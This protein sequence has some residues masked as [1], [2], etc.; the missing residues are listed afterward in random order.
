[1]EFQKNKIKIVSTLFIF[2]KAFLTYINHNKKIIE[3]HSKG[4]CVC[5]ETDRGDE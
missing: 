3:N 5:V 2:D 1:M 4:E